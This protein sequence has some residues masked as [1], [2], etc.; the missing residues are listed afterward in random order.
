MNCESLVSKQDQGICCWWN[1]GIVE[2]LKPSIPGASSQR[3]LAAVGSGVVQPLAGAEE[4]LPGRLAVM[5]F[6][7][8]F[9]HGYDGHLCGFQKIKTSRICKKNFLGVARIQPSLPPDLHRKAK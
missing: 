9:H 8:W 4:L 2:F 5:D 7:L 6:I 3:R 1:S